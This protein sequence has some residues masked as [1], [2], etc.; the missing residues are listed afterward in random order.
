MKQKWKE[1]FRFNHRICRHHDECRVQSKRKKTKREKQVVK[2]DRCRKWKRMTKW[3]N[4]CMLEIFIIDF[5]Q[6]HEYREYNKGIAFV[7]IFNWALSSPKQPRVFSLIIYH[8]MDR[9]KEHPD[10]ENILAYDFRTFPVFTVRQFSHSR[11]SA[12]STK[13]GKKRKW[14]RKNE[15]KKHTKCTRVFAVRL[16]FPISL[17]FFSYLVGPRRFSPDFP[18]MRGSTPSSH[19]VRNCFNTSRSSPVRYYRK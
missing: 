3:E 12:E 2:F 14:M 9:H 13:R 19:R 8:G 17:K 11:R 1:V 15:M 6:C 4:V 10:A 7:R 5:V 18:R 16:P